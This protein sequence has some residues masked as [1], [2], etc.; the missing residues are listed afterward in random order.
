MKILHLFHDLMNLYGDYANVPALERALAKKGV[1]TEIVRRSIGDNLCFSEFD[2]I[3]IGSGTERNQKAA[4]EYLRDYGDAFKGAVDGGAVILATGNSF[5]MFGKKITDRNKKAHEGLG[6]FDFITEEG[7][8]RIV[9]DSIVEFEGRELIG[10]V[11]KASGIYGIKEPLFTVKQ[12]AGNS[13]KDAAAE[14]IHAGN[15]Y[16]THI[17]GPL[18]IRNP[19]M[20][21][22]FAELLLSR[23]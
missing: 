18:L 16:G 2:L 9:T 1:E 8:E 4:L 19:S 6:L 21:E 12:G 20:A 7:S 23:E 22:Y 17:I 13:P 3:Y 10:F 5:E 15:F 11:N 14:G